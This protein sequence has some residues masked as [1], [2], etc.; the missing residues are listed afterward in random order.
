MKTH[1][2]S[3]ERPGAPRVH[4]HNPGNVRPWELERTK[5]SATGDSFGAYDPT[6]TAVVTNLR[7]RLLTSGPS[8]PSAHPKCNDHVTSLQLTAYEIQTIQS[9]E[10][11]WT[12]VPCISATAL[13]TFPVNFSVP[14]YAAELLPKFRCCL[15]DSSTQFPGSSRHPICGTNPTAKQW[16]PE[17]TIALNE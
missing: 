10:Y 15:R 14:F 6:V 7:M 12:Q 4:P 13:S 5:R 17:K 16:C 9:G 2:T 8:T 1:L 11:H 3:W